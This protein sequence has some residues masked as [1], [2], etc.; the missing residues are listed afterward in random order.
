MGAWVHRVVFDMPVTGGITE[1]T[2]SG[3]QGVN[4]IRR[5]DYGG[6]CTLSGTHR[7]FFKIYALDTVLGPD[8]SIDKKDRTHFLPLY[9]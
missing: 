1:N 8:G 7:Y 5:K 3:K 2:I 9:F 4:D 6:P